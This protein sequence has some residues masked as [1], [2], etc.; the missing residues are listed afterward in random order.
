MKVTGFKGKR[1]AERARV[2]RPFM[3]SQNNVL[4]LVLVLVFLT[5]SFSLKKEINARRNPYR[6]EHVCVGSI[7]CLSP[8][9]GVLVDSQ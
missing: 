6:C 5:F 9:D 1:G 3:L 7:L 4:P 8:G 2:G